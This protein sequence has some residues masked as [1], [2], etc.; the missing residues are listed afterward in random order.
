MD[1]ARLLSDLDILAT[2]EWQ[3]LPPEELNEKDAQLQAKVCAAQEGGSGTGGLGCYRLA[4]EALWHNCPD[5][6]EVA[7]GHVHAELGLLAQKLEFTRIRQSFVKLCQ[8]LHLCRSAPQQFLAGVAALRGRMGSLAQ[9]QAYDQ[10]SALPGLITKRDTILLQTRVEQITKRLVGSESMA[11]K[12]RTPQQPPAPAPTPST[13]LRPLTEAAT[14]SSAPL[15]GLKRQPPPRASLPS[16]E[17]ILAVASKN[18]VGVAG[19]EQQ[20][21]QSYSDA[22]RAPSFSSSVTERQHRP[23]RSGLSGRRACAVNTT[24]TA[25]SCTALPPSYCSRNLDDGT[26]VR[27]CTLA[28]EREE[29]YQKLSGNVACPNVSGDVHHT[30]ALC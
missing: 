26:F 1:S 11:Q 24:R 15:S 17:D 12:Q 5:A 21:A 4:L 6:L 30:P 3:T 23:R 19:C 28:L 7:L 29:E 2:P 13:S 22:K 16:S 18:P 8:D 14:S 25:R 10:C 20:A 9:A 27:L